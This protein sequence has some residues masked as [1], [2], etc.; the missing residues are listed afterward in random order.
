MSNAESITI[1]RAR[2]HE[3]A[4]LHVSGEARYT[5]DVTAPAGTLHGAFGLSRIAH[6]R[7]RS[8]DLAPVLAA[9]GVVAVVTA[10][11]IPGENNYGAVVHD[12]P[13]FTEALVEYAGQPLFGVVATSHDAARRAARRARVEYEELPA[14][15]SAR[16]A[17]AAGSFVLPSERITRG[18]PDARIAAAPHRLDGEYAVGGQDHFYLEG[19]IALA[20]P[21]EDGCWRILSS[22]QHPSE[23]QHV[24]AH[25]LGVTAKDV[26][27]EMRRMGGGFGGK[28]SQ[29]ALIAAAA[30]VMARKT[31]RAVKLRLDRDDDMLLTGKRHDFWYRYEVGFGDDG[32]IHGARLLLASRCGYS[33]DLSGPVN[34][35]AMFHVDNAY[36]LE[37]VDIVSHRCK[38]HTV[39]NTAFRGFG[40]PQGMVLIEQV[41]DEI[42]RHLGRDPL[43]VRRANFYG[44]GERDETHYRMKVEDNILEPLV[45]RLATESDYHARRA[46]VAAFNAASPV[47][48]KGL[49]LTPVKFGISFTA[50]HY[51]QAGA[52]LHVYNDGSVQINHG[53]TEMGQGLHTKVVQ[54]VAEELAIDPAR[55][56]ITA[57]ATD[58]VPNTSA[59]A[60]SSGSDLNGMAARD[61][62]RKIRARLAAFAAGQAG[63]AADAVV[64]ERDRIVAGERE[65]PFAALVKAAYLARVQLW[66]SGYYRTPKIHY[67]RATFSG[68]PFYYFAYGAAVAEVAIDTL[69]G[70][71][72]LLRV[73]ILHD[74]GSSLNPALDLGQVEGGFLQGVGWL[75][76]EELWWNPRGELATHAPST[77]KIPACSD[78]PA[79]WHVA[80]LERAPNREETIYRSKAVGEPPFMLGIAAF[81]AIRDAVAA[82]GAPGCRPPLDAPATPEAV[83]RAVDAVRAA[84]R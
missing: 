71:T 11:D 60:A 73:D 54:V 24:V 44:I 6:G 62:A 77:Y 79:E 32:R 28:E 19:Q 13:I 45:Q 58:K 83:L 8:L 50:T 59:T 21:Q 75:T 9:P 47:L 15:L 3:S 14:L 49:A 26:T 7:I 74:V 5:D 66:D 33:V 34:D 70:E 4:H 2:E 30:A 42:A 10:A 82:C 22:T 78:W 56:R 37:H 31:G 67:D 53:G 38:T 20:V 65:W 84:G 46:A 18:E 63:V 27:V 41:M 57:T 52:L 69:T 12:D 43:E 48:K 76:C 39:S 55:I 16:E 51:N 1:G 17:L 35:R 25:A 29:P 61:A 40:G 81:Q 68:R 23:V 64:F 72:R 36:C 80:L